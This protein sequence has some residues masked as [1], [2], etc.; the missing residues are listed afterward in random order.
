MPARVPPDMRRDGNQHG[1]RPEFWLL[2]VEDPRKRL[3]RAPVIW[4]MMLMARHTTPT[5]MPMNAF[6]FLMPTPRDW[7]NATMLRIRPM[8]RR[9]TG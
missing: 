8:T 5:M 7:M 2:A 9:C 6:W 4:K 3:A 1:C